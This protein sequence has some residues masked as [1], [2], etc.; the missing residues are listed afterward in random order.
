MIVKVCGMRQP[1]NIDA[2][3]A[4]GIDMM[5]FIFYRKSPRYVDRLDSAVVKG[6]K[7]RGIEPVALFVDECIDVVISILRRYGFTT[8]QLHGSESS[9]YCDELRRQGCK[10]LKA[11][12]ISEESDI[13]GATVYDG[14][15]DMLV[16]DTKSSGKGG[17]GKKFDWQLLEKGAFSTP[18]L[19]SGGVA[20][21]DAE[22]VATHYRASAGRM[23]GVDI[24]SR[25][26]IAPAMKSQSLISQFISELTQYI[27]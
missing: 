9:V 24:N 16:V 5:G 20:P 13:A 4:A 15:A 8:V 2:V 3:A 19:L 27:Q 6:L 22:A 14:H 12:S 1:D 26:E 7:A 18:Y 25:F 17:S 11:I 21:E 10:V 23:A